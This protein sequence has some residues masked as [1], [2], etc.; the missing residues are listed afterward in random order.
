VC[1]QTCFSQIQVLNHKILKNEKNF[2]FQNV[3]LKV[4]IKKKK[5]NHCLHQNFRHVQIYWLLP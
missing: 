4:D 3:I 5:Q 1:R 2:P